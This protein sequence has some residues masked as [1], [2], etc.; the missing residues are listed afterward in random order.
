MDHRREGG[1][2][3][4]S[5]GM[6]ASKNAGNKGEIKPEK[7][8]ST[9]GRGDGGMEWRLSIPFVTSKGGVRKSFQKRA[10]VSVKKGGPG[11]LK[12]V[13][14]KKSR[15]GCAT[16]MRHRGKWTALGR[17]LM[18]SL[19]CCRDPGILNPGPSAGGSS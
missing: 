7:W 15:G 9:R 10:R 11:L 2:E 19:V 18:I 1:E 16:P 13:I 5:T 12:L 6:L 4:N 3:E 14:C 8:P 17:N